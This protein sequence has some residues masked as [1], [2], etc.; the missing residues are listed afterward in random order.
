MDVFN[1]FFCRAEEVLRLVNLKEP[2]MTPGERAEA[3]ELRLMDDKVREFAVRLE[4]LKKKAA[5]QDLHV[6]SG[7][8]N[9]QNTE[10]VF[11]QKQVETIKTNLTQMLVFNSLFLYFVYLLNETTDL[12]CLFLL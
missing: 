7:D 4:Q 8:R 3:E 9:G 10:V 5:K 2:S 11:K 1:C 12:I 6:E